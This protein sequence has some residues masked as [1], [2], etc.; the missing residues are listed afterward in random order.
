MCHPLKPVPKVSVGE[1]AR[2]CSWW[3][4]VEGVGIVRT[5]LPLSSTMVNVIHPTNGFWT[6]AC[7][8]GFITFSEL[9]I[10]HLPFPCVLYKYLRATMCSHCAQYWEY[11]RVVPGLPP[12]SLQSYGFLC[13]HYHHLLV[14]SA[15]RLLSLYGALLVLGWQGL[16]FFL[17]IISHG[18]QDSHLGLWAHDFRFCISKLDSY[19]HIF[20]FLIA[21]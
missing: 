7:F 17:Y 16:L 10:W 13:Y 18:Q 8:S 12:A 19:N 5:H 9:H 14:F 1:E 6:W 4:E 20:V 2:P 15:P 11:T 3:M 21:F